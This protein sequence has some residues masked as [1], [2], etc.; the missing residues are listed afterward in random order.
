MGM[1]QFEGS[2]LALF[3]SG[4]DVG[5]H[6]VAHGVIDQHLADQEVD[7]EICPPGPSQLA[8]VV[9]APLAL[10]QPGEHGTGLPFA[11][12]LSTV[13]AKKAIAVVMAR[14]LRRSVPD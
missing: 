1:P 3:N 13:G 9:T 6:V 5:L 4:V 2:A 14:L 8:Q 12:A 7:S 11:H 10:P